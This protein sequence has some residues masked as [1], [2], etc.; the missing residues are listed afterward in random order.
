MAEAL[1]DSVQT[2]VSAH[3]LSRGLCDAYVAGDIEDFD[4]VVVQ[5]R[6]VPGE[7]MGFG[8]D[9]RALRGLLGLARGWWCVNVAEG[10]ARPLGALLERDMGRTVRYYGDVYHVPVG[11]IAGVGHGRVR[12]LGPDD[13]ELLEASVP[14]LRGSGWG[15]IRGL[16]EGGIAAGVP[17]GDRLVA[18]AYTSARTSG[19]A[20]VAVSTLEGWRG[21]G[22]ATAAASMVAARVQRDGQ[23]P[24]WS[25]GE[26]NT[27]SLRVARR[28]GFEPRSRRVYVIPSAA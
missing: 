24:V 1:G 13:A 5:D 27:A 7:P 26:D 3:L 6:H 25:C 8:S 20:D 17:V 18:I 22:L 2:F 28:L 15:G 23:T 16:L 19:Y 12:H 21:R 4:A 14:G 11:A 9:A 10:C